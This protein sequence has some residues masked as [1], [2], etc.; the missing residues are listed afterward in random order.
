MLVAV[1]DRPDD[2]LVVGKG[3]SG[4]LRRAWSGSV[5]RHCLALA[6]CPVIAVPRTA[7]AGD[8]QLAR[9]LVSGDG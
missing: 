8:A 5:S 4:I 7:L 9:P 2:L 6:T 1:A 3:R